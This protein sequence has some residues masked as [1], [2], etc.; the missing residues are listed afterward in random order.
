[1]LPEEVFTQE[2][3]TKE[4]FSSPPPLLLV[5]FLVLPPPLF[6]L[7]SQFFSAFGALCSVDICSCDEKNQFKV[8]SWWKVILFFAFEIYLSCSVVA[9][10]NFLFCGFSV[11]LLFSEFFVCF[12][13]INNLHLFIMSHMCSLYW[14]YMIMYCHNMNAKNS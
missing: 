2:C 7:L 10:C 9:V 6:P 13:F 1:M 8:Q 5:L 12:V 11:H 4:E 3:M 14:F